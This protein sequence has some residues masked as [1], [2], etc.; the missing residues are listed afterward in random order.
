M[1]SL[2]QAVFNVI[3]WIF[4]MKYWFLSKRLQQFQQG[5][6]PN[7]DYKFI[8]TTYYIGLVVNVICGVVYGIPIFTGW[9][10]YTTSLLQLCILVS[11]VFL[12]DAFR[13]L[14]HVK[15]SDQAISTKPIILLI[16]SF[17]AY[18]LAQILLLSQLWKSTYIKTN[19]VFIEFDHV[20]LILSSITLTMIL[21]E[22][23]G[24]QFDKEQSVSSRSR[25]SEALYQSDYL[26]MENSLQSVHL[27]DSVPD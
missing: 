15:A 1:N 14:K 3:H 20:T 10:F 17:G 7:A 8:I 26:S 9:I 22:L 11:C 24:R 13:R 18:G 4:A 16:I 2:S 19:Q 21:H 23:Q 6:N 25:Q 12:I 27:E 5:K